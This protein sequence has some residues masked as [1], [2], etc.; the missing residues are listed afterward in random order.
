M[1]DILNKSIRSGQNLRIFR[2]DA[3]VK[4]LSRAATSARFQV[5]W[6]IKLLSRHISRAFLMPGD[7]RKATKQLGTQKDQSLSTENA[8]KS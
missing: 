4:Q 3:G 8:L 2:F 1:Y 5:V 6:S 7:I